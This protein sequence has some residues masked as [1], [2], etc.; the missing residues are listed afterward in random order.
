M[1]AVLTVVDAGLKI[2]VPV[3]WTIEIITILTVDVTAIWT[4][5]SAIVASACQAVILSAAV[6]DMQTAVERMTRKRTSTTT[7]LLL[8]S[9]HPATRF[10]LCNVFT[11]R[12][13]MHRCWVQ[14]HHRT[15][16]LPAVLCTL[17]GQC[18]GPGRFTAA[19]FQTAIIKMRSR[20]CCCSSWHRRES[21]PRLE[22]GGLAS[23]EG[24]RCSRLR[25]PGRT[26]RRPTRRCTYR[27]GRERRCGD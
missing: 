21:K 2:Q 13:A 19:N 5:L 20:S 6:T 25:Q 17:S 8:A 14:Q 11:V 26:E 4:V 18:S 27:R 7:S 9:R 24:G 10:I 23:G 1:V 22:T 16:I 12:K 3:F 15:L